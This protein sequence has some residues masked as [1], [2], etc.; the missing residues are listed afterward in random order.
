MDWKSDWLYKLIFQE[1]EETWNNG[2]RR[3]KN[4]AHW[5]YVLVEEWTSAD[6]VMCDGRVVRT[7]VRDEN[8]LSKISLLA[9]AKRKL[10]AR[11]LMFPF[12]ILLFHI[13]EDRKRVVLGRIR[14]SLDGFGSRYLV[15]GEGEQARLVT[16]PEAGFWQS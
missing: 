1:V 8:G 4:P 11:G 13:P 9:H 15:Q 12:I 5:R 7:W 2:C 6:G 14:G 16:D 10:H 3:S